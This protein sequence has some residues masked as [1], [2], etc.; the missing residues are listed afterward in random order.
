MNNYILVTDGAYSSLRDQ[1]GVAFIFLKDNIPIIKYSKRYKH[2]TNS[3]MEM[4]AIISGLKCIKK[5]IDN[6]IIITDSMYCIGCAILNWKRNKNINLWEKF[7]T[8]LNRVK[9]LCPKI[10]FQH[11]KGHQKDDSKESEWNNECDKMAVQ[12]SQI[13]DINH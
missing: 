3:Q 7:D 2:C 11:V 12:A 5:P 6:L 8:E 10:K 4:I 13:I 9:S 1:G